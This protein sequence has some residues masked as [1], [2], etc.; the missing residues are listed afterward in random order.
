M[1]KVKEAAQEFLDEGGYSLGYD[2][3]NLPAIHEFRH[4]LRDSVDAHSYSE[5]KIAYNH[6]KKRKNDVEL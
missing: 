4:V 3:N 2:M 6:I 1:G 5:V